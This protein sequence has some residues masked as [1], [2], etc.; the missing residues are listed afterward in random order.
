M[1]FK[2]GVSDHIAQQTNNNMRRNNV[3][4]QYSIVFERTK[5]SS[6]KDEQCVFLSL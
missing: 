3:V 6:C 2:A 1:Q 5:E 4:A